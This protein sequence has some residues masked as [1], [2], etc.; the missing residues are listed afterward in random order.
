MDHAFGLVNLPRLPWG[1]IASAAGIAKA[2]GKV[3]KSDFQNASRTKK[4]KHNRFKAV[5]Q[6]I[7][8]AAEQTAG[9]LLQAC[10]LAITS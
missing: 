7:W 5:N 9:W 2:R 3:H 4:M 8:E 1:G 10:R 6:C